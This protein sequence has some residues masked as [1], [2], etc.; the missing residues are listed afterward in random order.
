V[1]AFETHGSTT[2]RIDEVLVQ[3]GANL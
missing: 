3:I 2:K 1:I